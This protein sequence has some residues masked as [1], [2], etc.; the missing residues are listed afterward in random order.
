MRPT[1][2]Q[3]NK[4]MRKNGIRNKNPVQQWWCRFCGSTS[5]TSVEHGAEVPRLLAKLDPDDVRLV[6]ALRREGLYLQ[7]I[8]DKFEVHKSTIERV[9]YGES[10]KGVRG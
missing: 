5:Y 3:C 2:K 10:Y 7:E 1:C 4:V 8:A 6:R 9:V